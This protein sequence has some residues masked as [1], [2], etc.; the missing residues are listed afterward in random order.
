MTSHDWGNRDGG[1]GSPSHSVSLGHASDINDAYASECDEAEE[2]GEQA[3]WKA[4]ITQALMDAGSE[5][6]KPEMKYERAQAISWLSG[7]SPDFYAV[8]SL[9]GM[10]PDYVRQK[11][12]EAIKRGCMWKKPSSNYKRHKLRAKQLRDEID[13]L[14]TKLMERRACADYEQKTTNGCILV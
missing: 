12:Q 4:V 14:E 5:S 2:A 7:L 3:L 11:A 6:K 13:A 9:A 8:C 1:E 10:D